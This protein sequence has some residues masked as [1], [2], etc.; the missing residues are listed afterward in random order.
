MPGPRHARRGWPR[1]L[2]ICSIARWLSPCSV[3]RPRGLA[4]WQGAAWSGKINWK[5]NFKT[6]IPTQSEKCNSARWADFS[7][8]QFQMRCGFFAQSDREIKCNQYRGDCEI[9]YT[10]KRRRPWRSHHE[11]LGVTLSCSPQAIGQ[12][13]V[14][15]ALNLRPDRRQ[16]LASEEER[17]HQDH[18]WN[19][20][21]RAHNTLLDAESKWEY[22]RG[23]PLRRALVLFYEQ[24]NDGNITDEH[25]ESMAAKYTGDPLLMFKLLQE[26]YAV[27]AI[28]DPATVLHDKKSQLR[29]SRQR[30]D[31]LEQQRRQLEQQKVRLQS[32]WRDAPAVTLQ[33]L[34][35]CASARYLVRRLRLAPIVQRAWR[36]HC[37]R[38]ITAHQ[39]A[40]R[41]QQSQASLVQR[42][43]R[44]AAAKG[45]L[46]HLRARWEVEHAAATQIGC[47]WRCSVA[48]RESC[49][50]RS[51]AVIQRGWRC[52]AARGRV[53]RAEQQRMTAM[54]V[55]AVRERMTMMVMAQRAVVAAVGAVRAAVVSAG[56]AATAAATVET[57]AEEATAAAA[58]EAAAEAAAARKETDEA[59]AN[60]ATKHN[61]T[62]AV[63]TRGISKML[64]GPN[65]LS[66]WPAHKLELII[67]GGG[68][69]AK[70]H[71]SLVRSLTTL[72]AS[73]WG[74][75]TC[76][77]GCVT[78]RSPA[79]VA[80]GTGF[81]W[82]RNLLDP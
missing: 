72:P 19:A 76:T 11:V 59:V 2:L 21:V 12:A 73:H 41:R 43:R 35:R 81:A 70:D 16:P 13:Y 63:P 22:E 48:R 32:L 18:E 55:Q 9:K 6:A 14:K 66:P 33:Q 58:A 60:T 53:N 38:S 37:A 5:N 27:S 50:L 56:I 79:H 71:W 39:R 26:E 54:A 45:I 62:T 77:N 28:I 29:R 40:G 80:P 36:C 82:I 61:Y 47:A 65:N 20:V 23:L 1:R 24:H 57:E 74:S 69:I 34:W 25:I 7:E 51:A 42:G 44:C 8:R 49:L 10:R 46:A 64:A 4:Q 52:S 68:V 15:H 78:P 75:S 67:A 30:H 31:C 3:G 17:L